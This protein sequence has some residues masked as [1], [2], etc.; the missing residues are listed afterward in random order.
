MSTRRLVLWVF[1]V[2]LGIAFALFGLRKTNVIQECSQRGAVDS[3]PFAIIAGRSIVVEG[4]AHD[5]QGVMEVQVVLGNKLV[6]AEKPLLVRDDVARALSRCGE[7]GRPGFHIDVPATALSIGTHDIVVQAV[8]T[9]R[10]IY[11][12]GRIGVEFGGVI[13]QLET[14]EPIRWNGRNTLVGWATSEAG[15]VVVHVVAQEKEVASTVANTP[16]DDIGRAFPT[17]QSAERAGFAVP[18]S[19]AN[20]PRGRY[21]LKLQLRGNNGAALD[22]A[23]PEVLNDMPIGEV[24]SAESRLIDPEKI[25]LRAWAFDED[26]ID[27]AFAE[28]ESGLPVRASVVRRASTTFAAFE[29]S[30]DV[31][32][33][34][35]ERADLVGSE[36]VIVID[37]KDLPA[38]LQR[39][40]LKVVDK[41]GRNSILPGPLT[42]KD[43]DHAR[44]CSGERTQLYFPGF[45]GVF[46]TDFP[47]MRSLRRMIDDGCIEV[48]I[49]GRVEYLRTTR[50]KHHDYMF[51]PDFPTTVPGSGGKASGESLHELFGVA[52]RLHA[53]LLITLDGGVWADSRFSVPD[54]DAV[55]MLEEDE[56]TVQWNQ[57]GRSEPDDALSGLAG[58]MNNPQLARMMSLNRFNF[59]FR[60]YK[61]RN[62]QAAV[63]EIVRLSRRHSKLHVAVSLDP[64]EYIN[65]WFYLTQWYDYNPDTLKEFR[66]W[67]FH[68]GPYADGGEMAGMRYRSVITLDQASRLA[69]VEYNAIDQ[70]EPP[71]GRINY[72]DS[73]QQIWTQFKRRLVAR[74]YDELAAWATEAGLS[75]GR[76]FTGQTFIQ[77]DVAVETDDRATGWTDQAGVSIEGAKPRNGHLGAILY[78][79]ASRGEGTPRTGLS[80][81][82]NIRRTD[83][84][85]G[86]VEFHPATIEFAA[87]SPSHDEAYRTMLSTVNGG[88]RFFSPMWGSV[89][90]DQMLKPNHFRSYDAFD[91][92]AFEYELVWWMRSL[93]GH[94]AGSFFFPFGNELVESAD[95]WRGSKET[96][97][98]L[99]RG[100]LLLSGDRI[101]I[102]SPKWSLEGPPRIISVF[103]AGSWTGRRP[104]IALDHSDG[105][106]LPCK[107]E[108][109]EQIRANCNVPTIEKGSDV[110][111]TISWS[112]ASSGDAAVEV[113]DVAIRFVH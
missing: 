37:G 2:V 111:L 88:S 103:V 48:G 53:P 91:G 50:G 27:T 57:Y 87:T 113:D 46:K 8:T 84:H 56:R 109:G 94:P 11:P 45:R 21:Q 23:G 41:T 34:S 76:I 24:L 81:L 63:R 107:L 13:G 19:M 69:G 98:S 65:P 74:H 77:A 71:R 78:G 28:T 22:L 4:W 32:K 73:W 95:G 26:G 31:G 106:R 104:S 83:D 80:L 61:K 102:G 33:A 58:S 25:A 35:G 3:A 82:E 9:N 51:D 79:P 97:V 100:K 16:R 6:A 59:R 20:L 92:T 54:F 64:D 12:L 30:S 39:L 40:N 72:A 7:I 101:E 55:D 75:S 93:R 44:P 89:A 108:L 99:G 68:L 62:L 29:G 38:G 1:L 85:W 17:W 90:R 42:L 10:E 66:E 14:P 60:E 67:L 96:R 105:R 47:Q 70:V 18:L 86:L 110:G 5:S 15:G 52:L 112:P 49:R 43:A 36:F